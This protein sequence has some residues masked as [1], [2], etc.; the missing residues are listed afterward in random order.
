ML[1]QSRSKKHTL[2]VTAWLLKNPMEF[3]VLI[4]LMADKDLFI[5]QNAAWVMSDA[6][7][8]NKQL[9]KPHFEQ[10]HNII[11]NTKTDGIKRNIL[12]VW[13]W[14]QIPENMQY[15][16]ADIC[17][18]YLQNHKETVAVK[19]FSL[20]VLQNMMVYIP[21]LK[22]EILFEIEKQLPNSTAAFQHR[23]KAFIAFVHKL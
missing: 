13:Q 1:A 16:V 8:I 17:L 12:R 14:V 15:N 11:I 2:K 22:E 4:T 19:A 18:Q 20:T 7:K 5:A 3:E 9:V 21:E 10:L 6:V 23:A